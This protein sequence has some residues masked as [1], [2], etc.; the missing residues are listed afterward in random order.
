MMP[1]L[2]P[3]FI[4]LLDLAKAGDKAAVHDLWT[5]YEYDFNR[6]GD[7]RDQIP[8]KKMSETNKPNTKEK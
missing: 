8:T 3:R 1:S 7:P 2:D 5:E 6:D 4:Q